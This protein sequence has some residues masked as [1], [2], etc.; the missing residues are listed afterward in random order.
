MQAFNEIIY[1]SE[2]LYA[3]SAEVDKVKSDK[4]S[5]FREGFEVGQEIDIKLTASEEGNVS[6]TGN[7]TADKFYGDGSNLTNI[8]PNIDSVAVSKIAATGTPDSTTYLRGDGVWHEPVQTVWMKFFDGTQ[9]IDYTDGTTW[10]DV[11]D[12]SQTITATATSKYLINAVINCGMTA[13]SNKGLVRLVRRTDTTDTA[14]GS[15]NTSAAAGKSGFGVIRGSE[16]YWTP[17]ASAITYLDQPGAGTHTYKIQGIS[18]NSASLL[19]VNMH[20]NPNF[21]ATSQMT[22]Q[23]VAP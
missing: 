10:T 15:V 4:K 20:G 11:T 5:L 8:G 9:E 2:E 12:M 6:T 3:K 22:I 17:V 21:Y 18:N 16:A 1:T 19:R 23:K 7:V 13:E 14:I